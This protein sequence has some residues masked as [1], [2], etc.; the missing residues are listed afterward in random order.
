MIVC[1]PQEPLSQHQADQAAL[2]FWEE[3]KIYKYLATK[4]NLQSNKLIMRAGEDGKPKT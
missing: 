1:K 4:F 2:F 3:Q